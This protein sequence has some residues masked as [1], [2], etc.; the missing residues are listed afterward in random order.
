MHSRTR[1]ASGRLRAAKGK[2]VEM[3]A[4]E[5]TMVPGMAAPNAIRRYNTMLLIVAGLGGLLYGVDVGVIGGAYP[6]IEAT[7]HFTAGQLSSI[8]AAVLLGSVLSTMFAG[9]LADG[10]GRK[11]LMLLSGMTFVLS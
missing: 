3:S 8:V 5:S 2:R 11:P 10:M 1:R 9:A 4:G 6:Y 7:S